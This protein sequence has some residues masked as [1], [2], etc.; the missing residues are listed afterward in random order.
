MTR[1]APASAAALAPSR[2]IIEHEIAAQGGPGAVVRGIEA[3]FRRLSELVPSLIGWL[4]FQAVAARALH[5]SALEAPWLASLEIAVDPTSG[6]RGLDA[7]LDREG[8]Q[9]LTTGAI[10]LFA[11]VIQL[12][13]AFIGEELAFRLIRRAWADLPERS[14]EEAS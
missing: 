12:L 2:W 9:E 14:A 10:L 7:V 8:A 5:L 13:C 4:G 1:T 11:T 3:A 6:I